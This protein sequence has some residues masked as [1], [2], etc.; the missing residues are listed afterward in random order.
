MRYS[1]RPRDR[2]PANRRPCEPLAYTAQG[3]R[4]QPRR[5]C[6]VSYSPTTW[7]ALY[8]ILLVSALISASTRPSGIQCE[9]LRLMLLMWFAPGEIGNG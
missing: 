2:R 7:S 8:V 6:T 4:T 5:A 1:P 9:I 3:S